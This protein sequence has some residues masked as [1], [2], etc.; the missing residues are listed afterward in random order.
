MTSYKGRD[1]TYSKA[2]EA[3]NLFNLQRCQ[4]LFLRVVKIARKKLIFFF[5]TYFS[6]LYVF[7]VDMQLVIQCKYSHKTTR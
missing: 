2:L 5:F 3:L 6:Y 4:K 7:I 1:S